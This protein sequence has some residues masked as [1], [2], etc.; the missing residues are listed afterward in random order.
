M[1][2]V[3][4]VYPLKELQ[5]IG[6]MRLP[7]DVNR[8]K[9]E[10][11]GVPFLP[12]YSSLVHRPVYLHRRCTSS[13]WFLF[14]SS[15]T[16]YWWWFPR[17]VWNEQESIL[18]PSDVEAVGHEEESQLIL[19]TIYL[20]ILFSSLYYIACAPSFDLLLSVA[21]TLTF[22]AGNNYWTINSLK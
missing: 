5:L 6:S 12:P 20:H 14:L 13:Y 10:V 16:S 15:A 11:C 22:P 2:V 18:L 8:T 4:P 9:L 19:N 1:F 7:R 3:Q 17:R 21:L